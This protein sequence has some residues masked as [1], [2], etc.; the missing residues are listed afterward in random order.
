M[1]YPDDTMHSLTGPKSSLKD[2]RLAWSAYSSSTSS[3]ALLRMSI[4]SRSL[5]SVWKRGGFASFPSILSRSASV[6]PM[7]LESLRSAC[8][9]LTAPRTLSLEWASTILTEP[10][11]M[12]FS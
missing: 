5:K 1:G 9:H 10:L 8:M 11:S 12:N 3:S 4:I 7:T 2:F 6:I